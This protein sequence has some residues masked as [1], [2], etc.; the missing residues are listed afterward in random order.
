MPETEQSKLN[1]Y[2]RINEVRKANAFIKKKKE[3]DGKYKVVTHDQV[4]SEV[5]EDFIK[6]GIVVEPYMAE[7]VTKQDTLLFT[8]MKQPIIRF[9]SI[10]DVHF[11]NV[12][13]PTER[14]TVRVAAH[15]LDTGDKAPGKACSYAVKMAMLKV[16]SIET[17]EDEEGREEG[18][19][20]GA[21]GMEEKEFKAWEERIDKLSGKTLKDVED[22]AQL[23]W[24]MIHTAC[25]Q[26]AAPE[27]KTRL[28]ARLTNK[29]AALRKGFKK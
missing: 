3:V 4:T 14:A 5:R 25:E 27:S 1:I 22:A 23:L 21:G 12:D 16:L 9:E 15:A 7:G 29:V 19:H 17:G 26:A 2:Q 10:W 11:V 13:N 6:H 18:K 28:R 24:E 8:K 20:R